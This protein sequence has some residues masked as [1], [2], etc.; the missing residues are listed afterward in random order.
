MTSAIQYSFPSQF[1]LLSDNIKVHFTHTGK[2]GIPII[3]IHGLANYAD[4]WHKNMT[5]LKNNFKCYAIDLPGCGLSSRG[6]YN[7][8]IKFYTNIIS[9]FIDALGYNQVILCGH[10]MGGHIAIQTALNHPQKVKSL[11][12]CAPSGFE[13]FNAME[14]FMFK[15][16][17]SAGNYFFSNE[18]QLMTALQNSF[19][20]LTDDAKKIFVDLKLLLQNENMAAWQLMVQRSMFAMLDEPVFF[21]LK[22]LTCPVLALHGDKD[23]FIPNQIFHPLS[24]KAIAEKAITQIKNASL[25][26][27]NNAGHFVFYEK[28]HEVNI[29]I[30][31]FC[32]EN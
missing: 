28:S 6:N 18:M 13:Y 2:K 23:V 16:M 5:G 21:Q 26:I 8:S 22:N 11:L 29:E 15:Q 31:K 20:N 32:S 17:T 4:V 14:S 27:I 30:E 12:L 7:Y 10:S 1:A 9:N 3:F 25:K 19:Y 24:P